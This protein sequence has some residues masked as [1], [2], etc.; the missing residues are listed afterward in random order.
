MNR[1][2]GTAVAVVAAGVI[3]FILGM[4]YLTRKEAICV[5]RGGIYSFRS[6]IC[7]RPDAAID[8][9]EPRP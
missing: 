2:H 7:L 6:K 3:I 9:T 8:L 4:A 5:E 1:I